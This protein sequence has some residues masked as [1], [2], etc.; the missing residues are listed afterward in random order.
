VFLVSNFVA[1]YDA[2]MAHAS[3]DI[4]LR[5]GDRDVV[6]THGWPATQV[7]SAEAG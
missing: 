2:A 1:P 3:D 5:I 6:V 7:P 4:M